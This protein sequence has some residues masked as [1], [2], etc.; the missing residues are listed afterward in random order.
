MGITSLGPISKFKELGVA[1]VGA[2]GAGDIVSAYIMCRLLKEFYGVRKC[3]PIAVLWERWVLDPYPGPIPRSSILNAK[4][5][6]CVYVTPETRVNRGEYE[7]RPQAS[8]ISEFLGA[9][10]PAFTLENGVEGMLRCAEE[11][12]K[13]GYGSLLVLDVGGDILA[14]GFEVDLWSPLADAMSLALSYVI[15]KYS[16]VAVLAPGADGE[17]SLD[18]VMS[19]IESIGS[20]GGLLGAIGLTIDLL[21]EYEKVLKA[22]KTEAGRVP[23]EALRG[24]V[25]ESVIRGGSRKVKITPN[26]IITYLLKPEEVIRDNVLAREI[27][28]TKSLDEAVKI[29]EKL[30]IPTELHLEMEIAYTYGTGPNTLDKINWN[31]IKKRVVRRI[32]Q[33]T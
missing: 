13:D 9:P 2:G 10:I 7:F 4:F 5:S 16:V 33:K 26:S 3:V 31:E 21:D 6:E 29:A 28:S 32:R 11:V 24:K 19:R 18:Y 27:V 17:L 14:N 23:Y 30:G 15:N 12:C 8:I 25:G 20:R 1:V 22:T